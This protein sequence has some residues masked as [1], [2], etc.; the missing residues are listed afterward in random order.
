M[1]A[2]SALWGT[3]T[4]SV[5]RW[6]TTIYTSICRVLYSCTSHVQAGPSKPEVRY[7]VEY[8]N[9]SLTRDSG[10]EGEQQG[11]ESLRTAVAKCTCLAAATTVG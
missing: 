11:E 6:Q 9:K 3:A 10:Y 7:G 4:L 2:P 1:T 8:S 5:F